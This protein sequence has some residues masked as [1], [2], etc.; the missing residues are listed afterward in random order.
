ME[1]RLGEN[2]FL[3]WKK[4]KGQCPTIILIILEHLA[5]QGWVS[6]RKDRVFTLVTGS[7]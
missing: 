3:S 7:A 1:R 2:G 6:T 4:K 5:W